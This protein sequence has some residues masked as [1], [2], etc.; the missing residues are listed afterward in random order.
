VELVKHRVHRAAGDEMLSRMAG[1]PGKNR[2][3]QTAERL[4][5][6]ALGE[7]ATHG[8]QATT[9]ASVARAIGTT[10]AAIYAYCKDKATLYDWAC[11]TVAQAVYDVVRHEG[12]AAGNAPERLDR[13]P[14]AAIRAVSATPGFAP[15][16]L[17]EMLDQ[18]PDA[19]NGIRGKVAP[20]LRE[21]ACEPGGARFRAEFESAV[22]ANALGEGWS[23]LWTQQAE[24][25]ESP[26]ALPSKAQDPAENQAYQ[27]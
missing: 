24:P 26:A 17:R 21:L 6:A 14:S 1:L 22:L 3:L 16:L 27:R 5:Q 23:A 2:R 11:G 19:P 18:A 13:L 12:F 10:D 4:N 20:Q 7:F 9:V 25:G 8:Y 15:L